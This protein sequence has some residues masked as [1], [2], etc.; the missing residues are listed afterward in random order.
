MIAQRAPALCILALLSALGGCG[1][2]PPL[3]EP[4]PNVEGPYLLDTKDQLRVV[5]YD[6]P[7]LT[8]LY[9]VDQSGQISFPLIGDVP[10]RG[11]STDQVG[12][13]IKA[14]LAT[15]YLRDPNVT[16]E[17]AEYRPFFALGEVGNPGQYAYV[18]GMTA[19]TA[20]AVAG[21]FTDRANMTT[22]RISRPLNG[23]LHEF[24][25]PVTEPIRPGDTIYVP[26]RLF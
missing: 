18:P 14:R 13:A 21:G 12:A 20:I 7:N 17:V 16:V 3:D 11:R 26:E 4:V 2:R 8:N 1:D 23:K 22:V 15:S 24:R 19:E 25:I 10:A 6:Q 9:E 5:V